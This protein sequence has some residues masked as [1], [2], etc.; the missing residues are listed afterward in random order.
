MPASSGQKIERAGL[1]KTLRPT[2]QA[3]R[4]RIT[5]DCILNVHR[6]KNLQSHKM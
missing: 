4:P 3:T 1:S 6:S 2:Y 5:D